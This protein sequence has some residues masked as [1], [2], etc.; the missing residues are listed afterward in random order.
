MEVPNKD[1]VS[2]HPWQPNKGPVV[3]MRKPAVLVQAGKGNAANQEE[4]CNLKCGPQTGGIST[5]WVPIRNENSQAPPHPHT[6]YSRTVRGEVQS[7][8]FYQTFQVVLIHV[9][10]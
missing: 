6:T 9:Q 3:E 7:S 8:R 2:E 4:Q 5:T 10:V 1:Y